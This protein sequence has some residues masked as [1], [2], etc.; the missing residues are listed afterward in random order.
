MTVTTEWQK[1]DED[2]MV[3]GLQRHHEI[4]DN[5]EEAELWMAHA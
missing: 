5:K 1:I 4:F 3:V 2:G